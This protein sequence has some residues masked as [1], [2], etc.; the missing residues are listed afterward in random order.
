MGNIPINIGV[1]A[2]DHTGDPLRT[3]YDKINKSFLGCLR[4][5]GDYDI[6]GDLF[7]EGIGSGIAGQVEMGNIFFTTADSVDLLAGGS[8]IPS[9]SILISKVNGPSNSEVTDWIILYTIH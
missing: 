9:G 2:N 8:P 7:P 1:T 3:A 6:S 4:L 5:I